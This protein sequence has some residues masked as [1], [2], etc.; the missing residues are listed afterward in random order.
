MII[1]IFS[2]GCG[3]LWFMIMIMIDRGCNVIVITE[4]NKVNPTK[5]HPDQR[6]AKLISNQI[7]LMLITYINVVVV[8]VVTGNFFFFFFA[9]STNKAQFS[10]CQPVLDT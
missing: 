2:F 5:Y 3:K 6:G 8:T 4:Q 9:T 1:H 7:N 10:K